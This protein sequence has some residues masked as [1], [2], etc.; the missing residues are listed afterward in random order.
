MKN[1]SSKLLN[2]L[3]E[4]DRY[5]SIASFIAFASLIIDKPQID[6]I[7]IF[8]FIFAISRNDKLEFKYNHLVT[9][10]ILYIFF[11]IFQSIHKPYVYHYISS[12]HFRTILC[13]LFR[14]LSMFIIYKFSCIIDEC[15]EDV[16]K[17]K[18]IN[19]YILYF[20]EFGISEKILNVTLMYRYVE[21]TRIIEILDDRVIE[22]TLL[23]VFIAIISLVKNYGLKKIIHIFHVEILLALPILVSIIYNICINNEVYEYYITN[24]G[25]KST[26][27]MFLIS[28][29]IGLLCKNDDAHNILKNILRMT[30]YIFSIFS[31]VILIELV[32]NLDGPFSLSVGKFLSINSIYYNASGMFYCLCCFGLFLLIF[33]EK[34]LR[35]LNWTLFLINLFLLYLS[36]SR[37]SYYCFV[38][39]TS[40]AIFVLSFAKKKKAIS[41]I[42][43]TSVFVLLIHFG[44]SLSFAILNTF[45]IPN[46]AV[47]NLSSNST[48][49][50]SNMGVFKINNIEPR[51]ITSE[52]GYS[53]FGRIR[54]AKIYI[55][56]LLK[57]PKIMLIGVSPN[58]LFNV[59]DGTGIDNFYL[60]DIASYGIFAFVTFIYAI[61]K[62]FSK[63]IIE[64][65][66]K[67]NSEQLLAIGFIIAFLA[68]GMV[69][70]SFFIDYLPSSYILLILFG[71][72]LH[73]KIII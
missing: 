34:K 69:E 37:G 32:F 66:R 6:C 14:L 56:I 47:F 18:K 53:I 38:I 67:F 40:L 8:L 61:Y 15:I 16:L 25:F 30:T 23:L 51:G 70:S 54:I 49:S 57:N 17:T 9:C 72:T 7:F 5:L 27:Y 55:N 48:L 42:V 46:S 22:Y 26:V 33:F 3:K 11:I 62:I 73:E 65:K 12:G 2:L 19:K 13:Y 39:G 35:L 60:W 52:A 63:T 50:I 68:Y 59:F 1:L 71:Y 28:I 41:S 4:N 58:Q 64:L 44:R 43:V 29:L 21:K 36:N 24:S 10:I 45:F 31:I 20:L